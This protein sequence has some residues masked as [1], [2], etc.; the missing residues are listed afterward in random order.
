M[1]IC[2]LNLTLAAL[3]AAGVIARTPTANAAGLHLGAAAADITPPVGIPMAGYYHAR[4]ADGVLD[5][6]FS[7]APDIGHGR[8]TMAA[9]VMAASASPRLGWGESRR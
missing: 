9:T 6:R 5:P 8:G 7:K 3:A 4:G 1:G 2:R